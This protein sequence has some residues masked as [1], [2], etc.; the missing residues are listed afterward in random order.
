M[1]NC[2]HYWEIWGKLQQH[3]FTHLKEKVCQLHNE[4]K[5]TKKGSKSI[6]EFVIQVHSITDSL[7]VIGESITDSYLTDVILDGLLEEYNSFVM[8]IFGKANAPTLSEIDS[9]LLVQESQLDKFRQELAVTTATSNVAHPTTRVD[10]D[11]TSGAQNFQGNRGNTYGPG[12]V[13]QGCNRSRGRAHTTGPCPTCQF[14]GRY[15]NSVLD[16]R[17]RFDEMFIPPPSVTQATSTSAQDHTTSAEDT[18]NSS[19]T[20]QVNLTKAM[21][22]DATGIHS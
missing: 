7:T 9:L 14:S 8:I 11:T 10:H 1:L 20:P 21:S 4:L 13:R 3:Y 2:H 16:C 19:T 5:N 18:N 15:G 6:S 12:R 17:F 22:L